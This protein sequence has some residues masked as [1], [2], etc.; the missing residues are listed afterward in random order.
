MQPSKI[1]QPSKTAVAGTGA[2]ADA[3]AAVLLCSPQVC[4]D[5]PWVLWHKYERKDHEKVN[6]YGQHSNAGS[7][8]D[9][10][11]CQCVQGTKQSCQKALALVIQTLLLLCILNKP[12]MDIDECTQS[13]VSCQVRHACEESTGRTC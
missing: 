11:L 10:L 8:I 5:V 2:V 1:R 7:V 3:A 4:V 6:P 9:L 13:V 12:S